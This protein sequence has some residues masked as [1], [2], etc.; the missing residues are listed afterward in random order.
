M[1]ETSETTAQNL[2]VL[3]LYIH[4]SQQLF[5]TM[6]NSGNLFNLLLVNLKEFKVVN[7]VATFVG[8]PVVSHNIFLYLNLGLK[9]MKIHSR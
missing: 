3:L 6:F 7:Y 9:I 1:N 8:N 4:G 2:F 5:K